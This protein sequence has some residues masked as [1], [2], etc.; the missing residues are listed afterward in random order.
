VGALITKRL[1]ALVMVGLLGL[2]GPVDGQTSYRLKGTVKD[3]DGAPI[4]GA[5]VRAEA[6]QGFRGEQFVGQ[7]EF[8]TASDGSGQWN[9]LGLTA[10]IWA[11]E[12]TAP[13]LAPNVVVLPVPFTQRKM[14]FA[15]GGQLP[16]ELP[17]T[18]GRT[19]N[20]LLLK[21]SEE[22][23]SGR[24]DEAISLAGGVATEND[25]SALCGAGHRAT[26]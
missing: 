23:M 16:W 26:S 13:N 9:I 19:S 7:K 17:L 3:S 8:V 18:L 22:A 1:V 14:Q 4:A 20:A 6:L 11:F 5:R 15:I 12:V 2:V 21:A 10:G 25:G 24:A